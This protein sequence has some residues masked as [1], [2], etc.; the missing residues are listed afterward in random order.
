MKVCAKCKIELPENQ[1]NKDNHQK[2]GFT[3]RCKKCRKIKRTTKIKKKQHKYYIM[4]KEYLTAYRKHYNNINKEKLTEYNSIRRANE[5]AKKNGN[6]DKLT[7][8]DW[9]KLKTDYNYTCVCCA[10]QE[11]EI[12]LTLDHIIPLSTGGRNIFDNIQPLCNSCNTKKHCKA[13]DY[14]QNAIFDS[15]ML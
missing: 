9:R 15:C 3:C 13:T 2:D 14:R 5:R 1:F 12:K 6:T 11:P 7:I 4:N 8:K 10:K